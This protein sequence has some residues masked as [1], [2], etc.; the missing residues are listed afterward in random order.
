LGVELGSATVTGDRI[1]I[2]S[3]VF[4]AGI[5]YRDDVIHIGTIEGYDG[6]AVSA[7]SHTVIEDVDYRWTEALRLYE[8]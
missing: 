2:P 4:D 8:G 5:L 7:G 6:V 1:R 3:A